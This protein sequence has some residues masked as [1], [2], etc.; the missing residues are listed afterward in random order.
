LENTEIIERCRRGDLESFSELYRM[1]RKKALGTSYLI[2]G[3]KGIA[4]DIVQETFIEC[5]LNIRKLKNP[6]AF[7]GWFYRILLRT[8]WRMIKKQNCVISVS[9]ESI[10]ELSAASGSDCGINRSETRMDVVSALDKLSLPLRT[11]AILY[12]YNDMKVE[13]I[14]K[15]LGCFTGTV[16]SRL[17]KARK[18]LY[19]ELNAEFNDNREKKNVKRSGMDGKQSPAG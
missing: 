19:C 1:Y 15:V 10:M 6:E 5:F 7:E 12:Y 8:G 13:D 4:D 3:H 17:Y 18:I 2:S 16:K 14:S 9:D 11:V